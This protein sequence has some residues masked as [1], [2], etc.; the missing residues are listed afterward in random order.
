MMFRNHLVVATALYGVAINIG[1]VYFGVTLSWNMVWGYFLVLAGCC[2]PDIDHPSSKIGSLKWVKLVSWPI[3]LIFGHR[4]ITHSG[5]I[6]ALIFGLGWYFQLEP[7][8]WLGF[9]WALHLI[10]DYLTDSGIPLCWPSKK[11]YRFPVYANTNTLSETAMVG[12]VSMASA[13]FI[14]FV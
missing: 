10:G 14:L 9:G 2:L 13:A 6:L 1:V 4:G 8:L 5:F 7:V 12:L 3:Y 11:R